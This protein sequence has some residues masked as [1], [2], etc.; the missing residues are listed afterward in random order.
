MLFLVY[1]NL[2]R[3]KIYIYLIQ[4]LNTKFKKFDEAGRL[5]ALKK[6]NILDS[7]SEEDYD[8]ITFM[9]S[10]ICNVPV[11]LVSFLDETRN[12]FKSHYGIDISESPREISFCQHAIKQQEDIMVVEDLRADER[13]KNNPLVINDPKVVFYAGAPL[14]N[15]EGYSLGTVCV[16]GFEKMQL[17]DDQQKALKQLSKRVIEMLELRRKNIDLELLKAK[18]EIKNTNLEQFAMVVSHDIKSPLT[19]ILLANEML[20]SSLQQKSFSESEKLLKIITNSAHKIKSLVDGILSFAKS[21]HDLAE[22]S[23]LDVIPFLKNTAGDLVFPKQVAFDFSGDGFFVF[24]KIQAEQIFV[25]L[26]NNGIRYN[27]S[28]APRVAI[29][30]FEN[31]DFYIFEVKDN[32]IGISEEN[33]DKIFELFN[34]VSKEDNF[35]IKSTGIGLATVK[36]IIENNGG[37]IQISSVINEGTTFTIKLPK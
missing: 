2:Q 21:A 27:N 1:I 20:S 16:F 26:I 31:K 34:T 24:N 17:S 28:D 36:K 23:K 29:H 3:S 5:V 14:V 12:W 10:V 13:F 11:A 35:G 9:A 7:L 19:S 22:K 6:Y 33:F 30:F 8:A 4:E 37:S 15:K 18:L 32:G 25:N